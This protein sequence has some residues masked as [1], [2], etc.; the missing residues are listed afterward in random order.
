VVGH[1]LECRRLQ[2]LLRRQLRRHSAERLGGLRLVPVKVLDQVAVFGDVA[3]KILVEHAERAENGHLFIATQ[4]EAAIAAA[5]RRPGAIVQELTPAA[6]AAR[7]TT[8]LEPLQPGATARLSRA[9]SHLLRALIW[10]GATLDDASLETAI[11]RIAGVRFTPKRNGDKV[12]FAVSDAAGTPPPAPAAA[13][14]PV[15]ALD[16]LVVRALKAVLSPGSSAFVTAGL[17]ERIAFD[18]PVVR[19]RGDLDRYR[20]HVSTGQVFRESDGRQ[21]D[22][23]VEDQPLP[24]PASGIA[25]NLAEL[26]APGPHSRRRCE[27]AA[28]DRASVVGSG[29]FEIQRNRAAEKYTITAVVTRTAQ[30]RSDFP[31]VVI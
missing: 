25:G 20:L 7:L 18:G 4:V 23:A 15:P 9:G 31:L 11:A 8:W 10:I 21:M 2:L 1:V 22:V 14:R 27:T 28:R 5:R 3:S 12:L 24:L 17:A 26:L 30:K 16:D 19:I 6:F 13:P 29:Q